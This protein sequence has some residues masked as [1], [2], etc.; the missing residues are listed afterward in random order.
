MWA[1]IF[2]PSLTSTMH[3][4][5]NYFVFFIFTIIGVYQKENGYLFGVDEFR[6]NFTLERGKKTLLDPP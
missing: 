5:P 1:R 3:Q 2:L 4:T 6:R